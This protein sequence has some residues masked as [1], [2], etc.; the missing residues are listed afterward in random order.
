MA[1]DIFIRFPKGKRPKLKDIELTLKAYLN[2]AA[3]VTYD[4][5]RFFVRF[6]QKAS[7]PL[8][9]MNNPLYY[10]RDDQ[11]FFEVFYGPRQTFSIILRQQDEFTHA[12]AHGYSA[13]CA[14][15]WSGSIEEG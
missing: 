5:D 12:V 2:E 7:G 10:E 3:T 13:F 9:D 1:H 11:R 6:P 15:Y 4:K 14:R 8:R